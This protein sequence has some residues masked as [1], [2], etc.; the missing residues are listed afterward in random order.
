ME[1]IGD[2]HSK[3]QILFLPKIKKTDFKTIEENF[4]ANLIIK[5]HVAPITEIKEQKTLDQIPVVFT[6]ISRWPKTT[7]LLCWFCSLSFKTIPWFEPQSIEPATET[8]IKL[9]T[10]TYINGRKVVIGVKGVFCSC[11]C[12]AARIELYSKDLSEKLNKRK[13]LHILYEIFN[14]GKKIE[15]IEPSPPPT[16]MI[17]YGGFTTEKAYRKKIE[18]LDHSYP[19]NTECRPKDIFV[20]DDLIID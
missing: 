18:D 1:L 14:N 3:P 8:Y 17:S 5:N 7:N 11:N 15:Q 2:P 9:P 4:H 12:V 19:T 20:Y 10:I 13:M 6:C 16:E